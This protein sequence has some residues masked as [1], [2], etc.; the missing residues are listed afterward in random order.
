MTKLCRCSFRKRASSASRSCLRSAFLDRAEVC[1]IRR[2]CG[3]RGVLA[4]TFVA[5]ILFARVWGEPFGFLV[6]YDRVVPAT[7]GFRHPRLCLHFPSLVR[8]AKGVVR[9]EEECR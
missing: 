5:I 8:H 1:R 9:R 3:C 2:R 7:L 6:L 4:D